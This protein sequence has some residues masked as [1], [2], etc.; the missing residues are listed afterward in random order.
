MT[1]HLK[2]R[3]VPCLLPALTVCVQSQVAIP[4]LWVAAL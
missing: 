3:E 1:V 4:Y 2:Q